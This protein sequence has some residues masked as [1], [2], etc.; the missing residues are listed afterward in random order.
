MFALYQII[1]LVRRV[2]IAAAVAVAVPLLAHSDTLPSWND[3]APKAAV[4]G[5]VDRV[6][7]AGSP[8]FVPEQ[9]RVAVFDND[10]TLWVEPSSSSRPNSAGL[11][12]PTPAA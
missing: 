8:D 2:A 5:F 12:C 10:G 4:V 6:T 1:S 7:K 11:R 3:T 9:E